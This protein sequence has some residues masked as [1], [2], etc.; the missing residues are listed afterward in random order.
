MQDLTKASFLTIHFVVEPFTDGGTWDMY[1]YFASS[2]F[3]AS[4]NDT[5][6]FIL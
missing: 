1:L 6:T 2:H 3:V 5:Y 4:H